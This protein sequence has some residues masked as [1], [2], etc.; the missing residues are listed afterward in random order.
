VTIW[1][2]FLLAVYVLRSFFFIV[3]MTFIVAYTMRGVVVRI[4]RI[5]SPRHERVWLERILAVICFTALLA[6]IA[7]VGRYIGPELFD[8]GKRLVAKVETLIENPEE[9]FDEV[10]RDTLGRYLVLDQ[11]GEPGD[12]SYDKAF[13]EYQQ[14]GLQY[15]QY[16]AFGEQLHRL[17]SEFRLRL[18][19]Q[20]LEA[21]EALDVDEATERK[22]IADYVLQVDY[23][24]IYVATEKRRDEERAEDIKKDPFNPPPFFRD[25]PKD[26]QEF[27]VRQ[28]VEET[29]IAVPSRRTEYE[30]RRAEALRAREREV[31]LRLKVESPREHESLF[32]E[33]YLSRQAETGSVA[34][35]EHEYPKFAEL[36][37][38]YEDPADAVVKFSMV[39]GGMLPADETEEE[40]IARER[41]G[42]EQWIR[43]QAVDEWKRG[44]IARKLG[45]KAEEYI[46]K[47]LNLFATKLAAI[48]QRL[49]SLPIELALSLL[50]SLFIVFDIHR[51]KKGVRRLQQSRLENFYA[52][53]APSLISFGRL[54]GRAFQAQAVIAL[55][56]TL[57]TFVAVHFLKIQNEAFLCS[58][59][60][61]CSFIPVLGVVL[62]SV[63]ISIMAIVQD[64]GSILLAL[65]A[66]GAILIIHFIE[67]SI[68]NPKILGD[69]L[70]LHP[71]LVL[72]ILAVGE[73]FF[74]VW[75]LLLG[76]PVIVYI[77]RFV[78]LDEGIPGIIEPRAKR[79]ARDGTPATAPPPTTAA[80]APT[81]PP[82]AP[83]T[84]RPLAHRGSEKS[85]SHE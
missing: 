29:I 74:G 40:R 68:L 62:S 24:A 14:Q 43:A 10:L 39:V 31:V 9:K 41:N 2:L 45:E 57:L 50:L 27:F 46:G 1:G 60:F 15:D 47:G 37:R 8:Q 79:S 67:A 83:P 18:E 61:V 11:Y 52:E 3:F 17:E 7:G 76:V 36:R 30:R 13:D 65:S 66:V 64:G 5:L 12:E 44:D 81:A 4:A 25:R 84:A 32:R 56:N 71:V 34:P 59:V 54:I 23:D 48:V 78:I 72:A 49:F 77:I 69:M 85:V 63:P 55:F 20:R 53:I 22:Q 80:T 33:F 73:H 70:H 58:I 6:A 51:L 26:Q 19:K 75:G 16:K 35:Y 28:Y 42:F 82:T 38:A 21:L